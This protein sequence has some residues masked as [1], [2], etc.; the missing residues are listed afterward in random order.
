[1]LSFLINLNKTA[2]E[3]HN[4]IRMFAF[5]E[6]QLPTIFGY[7]ILKSKITSKKSKQKPGEIVFNK[8]R[9]IQ[10]STIDYDLLLFK[11]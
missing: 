10:I 11:K 7:K 3:V 6:Y 8:P 5:E 1:M 2:F 9:S 4:Q